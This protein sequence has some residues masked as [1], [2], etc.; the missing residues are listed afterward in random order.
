MQ[1]LI[2]SLH[3]ACRVIPPGRPFCRRLINSICGLKKPHHHVRVNKEI[4]A[5]LYMWQT[6][7]EGFNGVSLFYNSQWKSNDAISLFSDS[8]GGEGLGF[9]IYFNGHWAYG[10]WPGEW[11][12]E[13]IT[14]DITFLEIVPIWVALQLWGDQLQKQKICFHCDN[15]AVAHIINKMTARNDK[16]MTV[17]R[18]IT[19]GCLKKNMVIKAKHVPGADNSICDALSRLQID[20]FK[21]MVP[22]ADREPK[23]L[24]E[25]IWDIFIV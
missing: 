1:S 17:L 6:F 21:G 20:R 15:D 24:P 11:H 16:V 4:K 2:G 7:M 18:L 22:Y 23:Q 3:F 12:R 10:Q 8:A 5:D 13:G 9:G 19:L 25:G 14:R